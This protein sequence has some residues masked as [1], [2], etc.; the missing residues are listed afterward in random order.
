MNYD[1][2]SPC[3]FPLWADILSSLPL[4]SLLFKAYNAEGQVRDGEHASS[5][6]SSQTGSAVTVALQQ[7]ETTST[8]LFVMA[9]SDFDR[10]GVLPRANYNIGVGRTFGF[11]KKDPIGDELTFGYTYENAGTH[12]VLHT[13]N[14]E[15]SRQLGVMKNLSFPRTHVF[16][17][18]T[19]VQTGITSYTGYSN[20][21]NR[22]DT[23][24]S[25]GAIAHLSY[26]RSI[27]IQENYKK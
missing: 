23:G 9:D 3:A 6:L 15:H 4:A 24:L 17:G 25:I 7:A 27:R 11:L 12:G 13:S 5:T 2:R 20:V 14:G 10:P 22:L 16:T 26:H 21:L 1:W 18:Y 19:W 8:D